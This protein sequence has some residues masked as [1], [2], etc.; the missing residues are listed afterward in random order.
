MSTACATFRLPPATPSRSPPLLP[1]AQS[2]VRGR[3]LGGR[4]PVTGDRREAGT[5][6][7]LLTACPLQAPASTLWLATQ[8]EAGL[9]EPMEAE[10][11]MEALQCVLHA[12]HVVSL[13]RLQDGRFV[14]WQGCLA[15]LGARAGGVVAEA[16]GLSLEWREDGEARTWLLR[17]P[18][19][20]GL[21][22]ALWLFDGQGRPRVGLLLGHGLPQFGPPG[23]PCGSAAC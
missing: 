2:Q 1:A 21:R 3:P 13:S 16:P 18:A 6:A 15:R 8:C 4:P 9:A 10:V 17:R 19:A 11:M 5:A 20:R 14:D 12:G 22:Q 7:D 23:G